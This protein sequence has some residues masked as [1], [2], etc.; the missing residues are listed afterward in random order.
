MVGAVLQVGRLDCALILFG[1]TLYLLS[2]SVFSVWKYV[3]YVA[4]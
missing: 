2:A 3:Y 4:V 1:F